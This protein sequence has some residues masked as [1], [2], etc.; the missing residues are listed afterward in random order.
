MNTPIIQTDTSDF[1]DIEKHLFECDS[2]FIPSLSSR[3]NLSDYAKKMAKLADRFEAWE[4][5]RLVGLVTAYIRNSDKIEGFISSVS[6]CDDFQGRGVGSI[7]MQRCIA[8]A[9]AYGLAEL[10]LEV[11]EQDMKASAFY[12]KLGF[13]S[14][15]TGKSGYVKM[16]LPLKNT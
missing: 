14:V 4:E 7:L 16:S 13:Q 12:V 5:E 1:R 6:V 15:G 9:F 2:R 10:S 3:V 11:S 8:S